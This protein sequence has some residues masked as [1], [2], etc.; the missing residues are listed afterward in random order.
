MDTENIHAVSSCKKVFLNVCLRK[1][2]KT[3]NYKFSS[4]IFIRNVVDLLKE[5]IQCAGDSN[6]Y[7]Q[8]RTE[9]NE[10]GQTGYYHILQN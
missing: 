10:K 7:I 5:H 4:K 1:T 2:T 8:A 3:N 6:V 9:Q